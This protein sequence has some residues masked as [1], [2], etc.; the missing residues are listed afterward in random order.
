MTSALIAWCLRNRFLILIFYLT[1]TLV[2]V[3]SMFRTPIDAIPDLSENQ[4]IVF[5]E[6]TGRSAQEVED[7]VT[8]PLS[9]ALQG[10]AGVKTVRAQSAFGF[11]MLTVIFEDR[12]DI[13]F[14]RARVLERLNSLP[15]KL[16]ESVTPSLGPD[17]TGLGW[18]YQY[19]LD[20]T[21]ARKN[22]KALDLGELRAVQDWLVRYQL[23]SVPGVA[24]VASLGGYVRQYQVD[25]DPAKLRAY[26]ITLAQVSQAVTGGNRNVGGGVIE[27]GGREFTLRGLALV[28]SLD[29]LGQLLVGYVNNQPIR[30]QEV[31]TI[32]L[33]PENRRGVL[34][35]NGQ[36]VV[37]G[38]VIMRYGESTIEVLR[39]IKDKVQELQS[40]LPAGVEIKPFYDRGGLIERAI[41]T[42]QITLIEEI[43]L[44]TLAH[45]IF[46]FHFRSILIVTVPLP[47]SIL[48]SFILMKEFGLTSNIMSLSGLAIAIGVLVDAGIVMTEAVMREARQVQ[49]GKISGLRYPEDLTSIVQRAAALVA[50]PIFFSMAIIILAFVPVFALTGQEG[51]LFHPLAFTKTFAMVGATLLAM[52]LVPV[53]CSFFVR[54]HI[55]DENDN[56]VMRFLLGLYLPVLKWALLHRR[57]VLGTALV[58]LAGAVFLATQL[59]REFMPPLNERALLFMPTTLPSAS[60]PEIKR[61]MAAQDRILASFPEVESVVG[62]LGRA[63]TATDPAPT[64]MLETTIT[65]KPTEEWRSGTTLETLK[66]EML[67]EMQKFPGFVPA[68]LQPI[69]N[70]VLMLSTGIRTQIGVKIFGDNLE[71]L[72]K[73]AREVE[74]AMQNVPGVADLYAERVTGAPYLEMAVRREDAARYGVAVSEITDVI[75]TALAGKMLSTTIEGRRRFPIRVRYARELRDSPE[76]LREVLVMSM[77][78]EPVP[79]AK[80]VD[81]TVT[82]GPSMISSENGLLR[83]YVQANVQDRDLGG[84]VEEAKK[85]VAREVKLPPGYYLSWSG[86]YENQIRAKRTLQMVFPLVFLIIFVLLYLTYRSFQEAAHVLL[87]VPFALTGGIFLQWFLDYNFSVAVWVGYIALFGTAVQTGVVMVVYLEEAVKRKQEQAGKDFSLADLTEAVVEGAALRLRPKVMTVATIVASLMVVMLPLFSGE[88][89][90]VEIMRPIAV[91]VIGGMVS[92]LLHILIVTPVIFLAL[93]EREMRKSLRSRPIGA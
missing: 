38:V 85:I 53:L 54:G 57:T 60:V 37:G 66:A 90:G 89:T 72:E 46:L 81:I 24:E 48:M 27:Q 80:V 16:P 79:L 15:F 39:R 30:L 17:A 86:Q 14:A 50:R 9:T 65:L 69:E 88:R 28:Q 12:I 44:V 67:R 55:H 4:V 45:I 59:G 32:S 47:L 78:G 7:Q 26:K 23:N 74:R 92:S 11:S 77:T 31:A 1:V 5:T 71:T 52:T 61:V 35:K 64:S 6:W 56:V 82:S 63:E 25:V 41:H 22:G 84:F 18:I 49:E 87:A 43:I 51:K 29:D 19:Y 40:A 75:E 2:G 20:D 10:L 21:E 83:V 13:Y 36:E 68:F 8:Y 76:A 62:K 3:W 33:G 91:P 42:L 70:R 93:R 34:D 58:L 73:I